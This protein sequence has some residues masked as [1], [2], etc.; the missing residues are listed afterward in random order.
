MI[1]SF[2]MA[3]LAR[4]AVALAI[5]VSVSA[6]RL[7]YRRALSSNI[8][9]FNFDVTA[10]KDDF[11]IEGYLALTSEAG[12]RPALLVLD[13]GQ[14]NAHNC[15]RSRSRLTEMGIQVACISIPGYGA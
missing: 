15:I 2:R 14:R 7:G 4:Y 6:C 1:E 13:P 5:V 9:P 12:P 11:H 8:H 10:G 3:G